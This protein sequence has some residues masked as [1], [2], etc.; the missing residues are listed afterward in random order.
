MAEETTTEKKVATRK[1][2]GD[3]VIWGVFIMLCIISII[4]VFSASSNLTY[5]TSNYW[6]PICKH[7]F[8]LG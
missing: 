2:K 4:E 6:G 1:I 3:P 5:K 8:L 7:V